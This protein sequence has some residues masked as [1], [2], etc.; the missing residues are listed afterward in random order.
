MRDLGE[1]QWI[2]VVYSTGNGKAEEKTRKG[3]RRWSEKNRR[4]IKGN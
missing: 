1:D 2:V 3:K 4:R